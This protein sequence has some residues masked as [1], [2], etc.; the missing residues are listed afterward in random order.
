MAD[1]AQ[2]EL[3]VYRLL[4]EH[5]LG[6]MCIHDL[7][8]V[9]ISI[10]PAVVASLGYERGEGLGRNLRDF[11]VPSVK[12]LFDAYLHRI[13]ARGADTGLMRLQTKAGEERVWMYRN[14]LHTVPSGTCVLGHALDIT[15][16][17]TAERDLKQARS[18]LTRHRDELAARVAERTAE[19]REANERLRAEMDRRKQMEEELIRTSKLETIAVLAGGIAHDFNNFLTIVLGNTELAKTYCRPD[20]PIYN[21]LEQ[22]GMACERAK[23]LAFQLLTFGKGGAPVRRPIEVTELITESVSLGLVGSSVKPEYD[24]QQGLWFAELDRDQIS[25]VLH[26]LVLNARQAMPEGGVLR[27]RAENIVLSNVAPPAVPGKHIRLSIRD[28]GCGIPPENLAKIFDPY[29][30]TKE[31]G[32]GL[33]LAIVHSIVMKH[34]G[35]ISV[36]SAP[37]HGTTFLID[38]PASEGVAPVADDE[39]QK[40]VSGCGRILVMDDETAIRSLLTN[41]LQ[42][43]GYEVESAADGADAVVKYRA[44]LEQNRRFAVVLVDLTVPGGMGGVD[45]GSELLRLD[46]EAK[47][48]ASSG[49]ADG[50]ILANFREHGFVAVLPK[51]WT[52]AQVAEVVSRAVAP[53]SDS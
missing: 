30:T 38:L 9:L 12:P 47:I 45:A 19:L 46:P 5:S 26:N 36:Q 53:V 1:R 8:G 25:Q 44:S 21:V 7:D 28:S 49:Y 24:L 43:L 3:D 11:L 35:Q 29:F 42:R 16:K 2:D 4:V 17:V 40:E 13:R 39:D 50:P 41:I 10:N 20:D 15:E 33:G 31:T 14:V 6:L 27:I 18:E 52:P 32:S 51:P 22:T 37:G 23:H 34:Q 48:I